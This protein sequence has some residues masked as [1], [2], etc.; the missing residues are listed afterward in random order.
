MKFV[1]GIFLLFFLFAMNSLSRIEQHT[2]KKDIRFHIF[3]AHTFYGVWNSAFHFIY[4]FTF[5]YRR[6]NINILGGAYPREF[7]KRKRQNI[8]RFLSRMFVDGRALCCW[9]CAKSW[10]VRERERGG[11]RA[12]IAAIRYSCHKMRLHGKG[13]TWIWQFRVLNDMN[14]IWSGFMCSWSMMAVMAYCHMNRIC[15][16]EFMPIA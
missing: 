12:D 4:V 16:R 13:I 6:V 2:N 14:V 8:H 15:R 5:A 7:N 3:V 11:G 10:T 1:V 9:F